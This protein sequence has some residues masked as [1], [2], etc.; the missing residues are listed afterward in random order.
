M[1]LPVFHD[2]GQRHLDHSKEVLRGVVAPPLLP[3]GGPREGRVEPLLRFFGVFLFL[4]EALDLREG[5]LEGGGLDLEAALL[6]A[7]D[8]VQV[9]R[10]L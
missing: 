5:L 8:L 10:A 9:L 4:V 1:G 6:P 7:E 2:L 3:A